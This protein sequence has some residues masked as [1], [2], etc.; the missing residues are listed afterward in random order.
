MWCD[1]IEWIASA[2]DQKE[3][4]FLRWATSTAE[5]SARCGYASHEK[6]A[7]IPKKEVP[8]ECDQGQHVPQQASG[9]IEGESPFFWLSFD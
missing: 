7:R 5:I 4:H 1:G 9:V 8:W 2:G 3:G 6:A